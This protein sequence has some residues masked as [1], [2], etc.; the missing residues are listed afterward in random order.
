MIEDRDF[1]V[2]D[3]VQDRIEVPALFGNDKQ[4]YIEIGSGKGEF[5]SQY[6][7]LHPEWNF[8]GFEARE[9]RIRNIL[10]KSLLPH[11]QML[12]W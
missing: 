2:L 4:L 9:K 1:F 6:A 3:N 7:L 5:I 12:D 10:K 11:I 8:L